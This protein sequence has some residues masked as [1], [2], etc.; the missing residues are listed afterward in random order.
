MP[1]YYCPDCWF[2]DTDLKVLKE[3]IRI[4]H[5]DRIETTM[6]IKVGIYIEPHRQKSRKD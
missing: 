5:S 2:D 6:E 1:V 3:H 4:A